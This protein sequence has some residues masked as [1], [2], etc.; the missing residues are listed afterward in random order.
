MAA[1]DWG[2]FD[3]RVI[4]A[5]SEERLACMSGSNPVHLTR[6]SDDLNLKV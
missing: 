6:I 3:R 2:A 1:S 5:A 4:A